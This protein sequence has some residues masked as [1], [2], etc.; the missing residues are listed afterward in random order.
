VAVEALKLM[1]NK[2]PANTARV[3]WEALAKI[4]ELG[5]M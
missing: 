4:K 3:S 1:A 5:E 2:N